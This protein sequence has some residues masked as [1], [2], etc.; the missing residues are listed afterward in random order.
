MLVLTE[1]MVPKV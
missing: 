1:Q